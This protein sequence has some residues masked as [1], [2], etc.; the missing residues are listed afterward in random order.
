MKTY[1]KFADNEDLKTRLTKVDDTLNITSS[2]IPLMYDKNNLYID[3]KDS[4]T[5]IIGSTGSGKTQTTVLPQLRL[6]IA[7]GESIVVVDEMGDIYKTL[8]KELDK[9]KY[10]TLVINFQDTNKSNNFNPLQLPYYLYKNKYEDQSIQ[11]VEQIADSIF[12]IEKGNSDPFWTNSAK[13]YFIGLTLYLFEH[14]KENEINYSSIYNLSIDIE[15]KNK[16]KEILEKLDPTSAA[17]INLTSIL[18]APNET[19][20][21]ILSV[22]RQHLGLITSKTCLNNLLANSDYNL[23]DLIDDKFAIFIIGEP[24]KYVSRQMTTVITEIYDVINIKGKHSKRI[25]VILDR[26]TELQPFNS[27]HNILSRSRSLN[28]RYTILVDS[29]TSLELIYGKEE[30]LLIVNNIASIIYLLTTDEQTNQIISGL[31]GEAKENTPLISP[32][33]LKTLKMFE[34]IIIKVRELPIKTKLMPDF[35]IPWEMSKE[36][37]ELPTRKENIIKLYSI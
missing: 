23:F 13:N 11:I 9:Q 29:L 6:S 8:G 18:L 22:F 24:L 12:K 17:S 2:G 21:G 1:A 19:R 31:I 14:A 16:S 33:E 35:K 10:K 4:H 3:D 15:S 26:F 25:N 34:A 28:I 36:E 27:F 7:T 32:I 20:G 37:K 30:T 5:L